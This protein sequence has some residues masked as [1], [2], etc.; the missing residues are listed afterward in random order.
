LSQATEDDLTPEYKEERDR[1]MNKL[2]NGL[3]PKEKNGRPITG[4]ELATLLEILV[5]AANEGSLAEIPGRWQVFIDQL[6]SSAQEDC[7]AFYESDVSLLLIKYENSAVN[8]TELLHWHYT[9]LEKATTLLKQLLFGLVLQRENVDCL[10]ITFTLY[11]STSI[12][13]TPSLEEAIAE[14]VDGLNK[15]AAERFEKIWDINDKKIQLK[16]GEV[17][18]QLERQ[19][20][21]SRI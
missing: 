21:N 16:C 9:S 7:A 14:A 1:L 18:R 12:P 8:E 13:T 3:V 19:K 17:Q 5:T 4:P 2:K 15:T 10:F 6:Q 20:S 11:K